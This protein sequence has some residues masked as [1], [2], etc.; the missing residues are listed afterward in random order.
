VSASKRLFLTINKHKAVG[1]IEFSNE[2]CGFLR[3]AR[4][5][6]NCANTISVDADMNRNPPV[7][8]KRIVG[9]LPPEVIRQA[10]DLI[11]SGEVMKPAEARLFLAEARQAY[12]K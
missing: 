9:K 11:E 3:L 1:R 10:L 7:K 2:K 5:F 8:P 6:L 12:P 4:N